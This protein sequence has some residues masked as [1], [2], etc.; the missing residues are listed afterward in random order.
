MT[1]KSILKSGM[2]D[3]KAVGKSLS[4][5][6]PG[7]CVQTKAGRFIH[8]KVE[9]LPFA[10]KIRVDKKFT[11]KHQSYLQVQVNGNLTE[12]GCMI[13]LLQSYAQ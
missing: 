13:I 4:F 10:K 3:L 11:R 2:K 5:D 7:T 12:F 8:G 9:R 1:K 6:V